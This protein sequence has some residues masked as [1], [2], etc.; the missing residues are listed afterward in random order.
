MF[1]KLQN[2]LATVAIFVLPQ[3]A[4]ACGGDAC[5]FLTAK[6]LKYEP[7]AR[8]F[9]FSLTNNDKN[10][11]I[12]V[13]GCVAWDGRCGVGPGD[14]VHPAIAPGKTVT[15]QGVVPSP[16]DKQNNSSQIHE[17][18]KEIVLPA[19]YLQ[20]EHASFI[21]ND[22]AFPTIEGNRLYACR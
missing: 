21:P 16:K 14:L 12:L 2:I 10:R 3:V 7:S 1:N 4:H 15:C 11:I 6:N 17:H 22:K 9:T 20:V 13:D 19:P 8:Y 18:Q 5:N